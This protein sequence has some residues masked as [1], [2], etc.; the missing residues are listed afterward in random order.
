[1][2]QLNNAQNTS[3]ISTLWTYEQCFL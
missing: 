3:F 1:M 2:T